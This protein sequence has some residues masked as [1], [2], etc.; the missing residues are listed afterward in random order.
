MTILGLE[1]EA[2]DA[3]M[4]TPG[5]FCIAVSC[6]LQKIAGAL[7]RAVALRVGCRGMS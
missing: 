6:H 1:V 2:D 7:A 4:S 3:T 5:S